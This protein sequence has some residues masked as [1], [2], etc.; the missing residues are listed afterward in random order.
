VKLQWETGNEA[1]ILAFNILRDRVGRAVETRVVNPAPIL[2]AW[3]GSNQG[4]TYTFVDESA[5]VGAAYLYTLEVLKL[6]GGRVTYG[7][8]TVQT[9]GSNLYLPLIQR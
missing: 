9:H 3:A 4:E 2:A 6:S 1:D 5:Q 8:V 7:P